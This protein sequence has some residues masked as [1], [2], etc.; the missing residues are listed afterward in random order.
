MRPTADQ[1]ARE[2]LAQ[3]FPFVG[4]AWTD[5]TAALRARL[6]AL[7]RPH[8]KVLEVGSWMGFSARWFARQSDV[9]VVVC[10]DPWDRDQLEHWTPGVHPE[11]WMTF[12]YEHFLANCIHA[13]VADKIH[14]VRMRSHDAA[15]Q[16][17]GERFDL[18]Y[19]DGAHATAA[20]RQDLDDY[21]PL[22]D[23]LCGDDWLF[24]SEPDNV[25]A[26]VESFAK[27]TGRPVQ[28]DGNFWW[29]DPV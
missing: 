10:V 6:D 14:P 29:F 16:F 20:V 26:A 22:A 24:Q 27:D 17:H 15:P 13:G 23:V 8:M 9:A 3:T 18:I 21:A 5:N 1:V 11:H 19:I 12:M 7:Q 25:R 28:V 2:L 4:H